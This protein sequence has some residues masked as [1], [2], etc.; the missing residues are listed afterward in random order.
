MKTPHESSLP[1]CPRGALPVWVRAGPTASH[2]QAIRMAALLSA[3]RASAA[4]CGSGSS[5]I[6]GGVLTPAGLL[7]CHSPLLSKIRLPSVTPD[8][9]FRVSE[10]SACFLGRYSLTV[11]A[12]WL[13]CQEPLSD[14]CFPSMFNGI[15]T[16]STSQTSQ[17]ADCSPFKQPGFLLEFYFLILRP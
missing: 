13:I 6:P 7:L 10:E 4:S 2:T 5:L 11:S 16:L 8:C 1:A 17:E 3:R 9:S 14:V 15:I 12:A